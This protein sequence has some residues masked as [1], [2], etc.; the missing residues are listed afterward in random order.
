MPHY[1]KWKLLPAKPKLATCSLNQWSMDFEGNKKNIIESIQIAKNLRCAYRLG[2]ELEVTGYSCEDHFLETDTMKHSWEVLAEILMSDLTNG[3]MCDIGMPVLFRGVNYNCRVICLNRKVVLIRPK[4]LLA[5][6]GN[7]R[8][9]RWFT[10]WP[11]RRVEDFLLP[12]IVQQIN[13]QM[14]TKIGDALLHLRDT[15]IGIET[16]EELWNPMSSHI[17][18]GLDG[19]EIIMN[20]SGSHHELRKLKARLGLI[21]E[22]TIK[23]CTAYL[24]FQSNWRRWQQTLL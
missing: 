23:A 16:C 7:Y 9:N 5:D 24:V 17:F 1:S 18:Q 10:A 20:S 22:A 14:H 19:A 2:P 4:I 11:R 15:E 13:G 6:D 21:T 3:I 12:D 8:E